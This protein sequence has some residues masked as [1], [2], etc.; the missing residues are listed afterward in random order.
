MLRS[1][2]FATLAVFLGLMLGTTACDNKDD[3]PQTGTFKVTIENTSPVYKALKSGAFTTPVGT[4]E[5]APIFPGEAYEI[6][7]TAPV[8]ARLSAVTMFV[9]S[10]DWFYATPEDG[11]ALYNSD[12][13]QVTGDVTSSFDLYDAGTEMDQEPGTGSDQ[14]PRQSGPDTGA[15]DSNN[16]VRL[17][18]DASVPANE[19]VIQ[20]T[21]SS[22][23]T[24]AFKLRIENVS[25]GMTL[26][27]SE[28][29]KA[30]PLSPGI[31]AVHAE[32]ESALFFSVGSSDF[33]EGLE[34]IAEDGDPSTLVSEWE[35]RTGVTTPLAP[36]A[37]AVFKED[38]DNPM[39]MAGSPNYGN[40]LEALAEDADPS[41]ISAALAGSDQ[42][43]TSGVFNMPDGS[44]SAGPI[45]PGD[46]FSFSFEA[47]EG[48][49]LTFGTMYGQSNDL[50]YAPSQTA[51]QLFENGTPVMGD[52]TDM[53]SLWDAGTEMNQEPGVGGDQAPRQA[54]PDTGADDPNSNVRMVDDGYS[55][56]KVIKVTIEMVQ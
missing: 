21:L 45:F 28:G 52:V 25:D 6:A 47:Q 3:N 12:G 37:Y 53:V 49:Q 11:I 29:G 16:M 30:V 8:G 1:K 10:N 17:V 2:I 54:G 23:G 24:N 39:F 14:A 34:A 15:D 44:S 9:Q 31:F 5:P 7:F 4:G 50:F 20:V 48:D 40:G 19:E 46:T 55:Y 22:T 51:I 13:N 56:E 42:V 33:G 18:D 35:D 26:Q 36:G 41:M 32:S 43:R 27:T 38:T